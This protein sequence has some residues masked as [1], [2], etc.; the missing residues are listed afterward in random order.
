MP[1][2]NDL[3][4]STNLS[5]MVNSILT[6]PHTTKK[7]PNIQPMYQEE[8]HNHYITSEEEGSNIYSNLQLKIGGKG[9]KQSTK[10]KQIDTYTKD[11]LIKM[12]KKHGIKLS[13]KGVK[14][15]K[16]QLFNSL[17]RKKLI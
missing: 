17:K 14:R 15:T 13:S 5:G 12:A 6:L 16:E 10:K 9:K 7:N 4:S 1:S 11:K 8:E 3:I 2:L